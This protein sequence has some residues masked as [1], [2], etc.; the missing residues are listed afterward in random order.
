MAD[1]FIQFSFEFQ[2]TKQEGEALLKALDSLLDPGNEYKY[3]S[4]KNSFWI[5]NLGYGEVEP[6]AQEIQNPCQETLSLGPIGFEWSHSCSK[7]EIDA[8]GGGYCIITK[9][10]II[11]ES[12]EDLL[13]QRL[14]DIEIFYIS[15]LAPYVKKK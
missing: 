7:P 1:H 14:R 12:T 8:F 9:D 10:E 4:D 15:E 2:C 11:I 13:K 6:I 3:D 5:S